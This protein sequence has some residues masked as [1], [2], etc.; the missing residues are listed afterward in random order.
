VS[1]STCDPSKAASRAVVGRMRGAEVFA[2]LRRAGASA[3]ED[4][5]R[6]PGFILLSRDLSRSGFR[7][8][9]T[10]EAAPSL[11]DDV[12]LFAMMSIRLIPPIVGTSSSA[13]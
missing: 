12:D 1:P 5:S 13:A 9:P 4:S 8:V 10:A 6:V 2:L 7:V 11:R 3:G